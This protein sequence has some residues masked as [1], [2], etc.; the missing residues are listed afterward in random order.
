MQQRIYHGDLEPID[1]C[2]NLIAHFNRGNLNVQ[3]VG[4]GDKIALQIASSESARSG[5]QTALGITLLKVPD[6]ISIQVGEQAWFGL[7]ASLG[8]TALA[9][10]HDPFSLISRLD[11]LAQDIENIQLSDE[12][13]EVID[14]TARSLGTGTELSDRLRTVECAYCKTANPVREPHCIACG[15]PL[16]EEQPD[17]CPNCGFIIRP[18][19][20]I[21][22]NCKLPLINHKIK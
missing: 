8:T 1:I 21:C 2:N 3:Q 7:A 18:D 13:W 16:G 14:S 4:S 15:A 17:T 5:G 6:G 10:L 11:D 19:E 9:A 12:V 20:D 22:P